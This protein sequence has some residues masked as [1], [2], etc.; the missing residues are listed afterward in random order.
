MSLLL[1]D[2]QGQSWGGDS[3]QLREAFDSPYS[4]GEFV[5]YAVK[6]LGFVAINMY[7]SSCQV[8]LRP[9]FVT[10]KTAHALKSWATQSRL[11]R[12]VLSLFPAAADNAAPV[13]QDRTWSNELVVRE[14]VGQRL[15]ELLQTTEPG[16]PDDFLA[17]PISPALL[18]RRPIVSDVYA[19]WPHLLD[20][21]DTD[22]LVRLLRSAFAG[23]YALLKKP[24][25]QDKVIFR[26]F[27]R[28][29]FPHSQTWRECAVGAPVEEQPDRAYGR[30]IGKTYREAMADNGASRL[31]AV[32]AIMRCPVRGRMRLRYHRL[33]LKL[34]PES[35]GELF[36]SGSFEDAAIDLRVRTR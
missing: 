4:G 8:R 5:E 36:V 16:R 27:G 12:M 31:E 9:G 35:D 19:T 24:R 29:M 2:D 14:R 23:R 28:S 13:A 10:E 17:S 21:Y 3:R 30:W 25:D 20:T 26:E 22:T 34:P 11:Q 15:D 7:G 32:D 6:N 33:L 18:D 1:I